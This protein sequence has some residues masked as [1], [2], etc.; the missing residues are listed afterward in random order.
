MNL[1]DLNL[2]VRTADSGSIT[3]SAQ[4]LD[5]TPAAASAALKR[6]EKQLDTQLFIRST[7]QL[8]ITDEGERFLLHCRQALASIDEGKASIQQSQ[9]K[10]AGQLRFS[11]SSDLGRNLV[12]PWLD[13]AMDEHPDLSLNLIVGDSV[14][15]FY[16]DRVDVAMR[17]GELEDSSM[18]AF[19]LATVDR[20]VCASPGYLAKQGEPQHPNELRNHN[21]L[22][23]RLDKG[24]YDTWEFRD[25][26]GRYRVKVAGNRESNDAEIV[27][28]WAVADKG[29]LF[30]SRLDVAMDL[31]HGRLVQLFKGF[32][33]PP[34]KVWLICPS[35]RQVTPAVL[36]LRDLLRQRCIE[37]LSNSRDN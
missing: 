30:K 37:L 29:V 36:M 23:Y 2:F 34:L 10:I 7:R 4:Q 12:Q 9:G 3:A 28:R 14:S 1:T 5:I 16:L 31:Q 19:E 13:E 11:V 35:R 17:Y 15:D 27:R 22:L 20:I 6:L 24:L 26:Q 21:C 18:V 25:D 32:Q 33:T 8:R